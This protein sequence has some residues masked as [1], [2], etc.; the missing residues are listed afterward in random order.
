[1]H[2]LTDKVSCDAAVEKPQ[3]CVTRYN[4]CCERKSRIKS[5]ETNFLYESYSS[6]DPNSKLIY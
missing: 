1:M 4:S 3:C 5:L 2:I 6:L